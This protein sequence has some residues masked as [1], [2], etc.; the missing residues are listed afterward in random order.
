M[1][2]RPARPTTLQ[3]AAVHPAVTSP[4]PGQGT[5]DHRMAVFGT[6]EAF[7]AAALPFLAEGLAAS[8][9]PPPLAIVAPDKLDLL[10]DALGT[11]AKDVGLLPHTDWYTGSAANAVARAARHLA[12]QAGPGGRC[13]LL[14]EPVWNGRAGRSPRESAEWIR[15]EA[16]A[17]LLFAPTA[18]TAMCVYD[19]RTAGAVVVEAARR[20][21]PATGVYADPFEIAAELDA[22]PLAPVPSEAELLPEPVP[23]AV[24]GWAAA[25]GLGPADA[26]LFATAV[27]EAAGL[28]PVTGALLWG[29]APGCCCELGLARRVDDPLA[30]FVPPGTA[31]PE[32]GQGLW[33]A[34]QVCAYVDVRAAAGGGTSVR[35]Q[36]G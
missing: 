6:D 33:F 9:E 34:R 28:G 2:T 24:R 8:H 7:V 16:L 20:A 25:R 36:Y 5:F 23:E 31:A 30:G 11:T 10:R 22:V 35:L 1:T 15:Y 3:P 17:N 4:P 12:T 19:T 29:E 14:M 27:A 21:H 18:T 32:P 26:E 13:H